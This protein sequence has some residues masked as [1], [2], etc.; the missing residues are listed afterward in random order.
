[1][2]RF[3]G[4]SE[5]SSSIYHCAWENE[6]GTGRDSALCPYINRFSD[7]L[8]HCYITLAD[9]EQLGIFP[10]LSVSQAKS[11]LTMQMKTVTL[12]VETAFGGSHLASHIL[13]PSGPRESETEMRLSAH[14]VAYLR[15]FGR[16]IQNIW[17]RR[18]FSHVTISNSDLRKNFP[19]WL[20]LC[21][22]KFYSHTYFYEMYFRLHDFSRNNFISS[23]W[24]WLWNGPWNW[25][26]L[27]LS[28]DF[29]KR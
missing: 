24:S 22:E 14:R 3:R 2:L 8:W 23:S 13:L 15:Q 4:T 17:E 27:A 16:S 12:S 19:F 28:L 25:I 1:M 11:Q 21:T 6:D 26:K 18:L 20:Y 29:F 10:F 5:C 7:R 9:V